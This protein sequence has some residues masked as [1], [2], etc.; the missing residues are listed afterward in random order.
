VP[1]EGTG[2]EGN[3]PQWYAG[4]VGTTGK[5]GREKGLGCAG[6]ECIHPICPKKNIF[7]NHGK[8]R[9]WVSFWGVGLSP[10]PPAPS[11]GM[12]IATP[13]AAARGQQQ[14]RVGGGSG[15]GVEGAEG[16]S[17]G[18]RRARA[19]MCWKTAATEAWS[20]A[21]VSKYRPRPPGAPTVAGEGEGGG[22]GFR[23][24][25]CEMQSLCV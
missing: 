1:R 6:L 16:E 8:G 17:G 24:G 13:A 9:G 12:P 14:R 22:S 7:R 15:V 19:V 4:A 21:L 25:L 5:G 11:H 23:A 18:L 3:A 2:G 10:T 20:S